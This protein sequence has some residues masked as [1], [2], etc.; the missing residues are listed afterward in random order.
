MLKMRGPI[1]VDHYMREILTNPQFGYYMTRNVF[2]RSG[3]F[4]TAPEL[5]QLF[6]DVSLICFCSLAFVSFFI[7]CVVFLVTSE[8]SHLTFKSCKDYWVVVCV[9][10]GTFGETSNFE[11]SG[12]GSRTRDTSQR[13]SQGSLSLFLFISHILTFCSLF[14]SL[15]YLF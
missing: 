6:G 2:G 14:H 5:S 12:I 15:T 13:H 10:V 1:S 7:S 8:G 4:I 9:N 3:D 11:I